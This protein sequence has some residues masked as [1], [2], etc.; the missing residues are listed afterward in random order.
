M[1]IRST[2]SRYQPIPPNYAL[3][4]TGPYHNIG[5]YRLITSATTSRLGP[6][7]CTAPVPNSSNQQ[8]Q[9]IPRISG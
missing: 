2:T 4:T 7:M 6:N 3:A 8:F 1:A 9:Y 5:R